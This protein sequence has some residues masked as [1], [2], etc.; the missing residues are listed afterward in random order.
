MTEQAPSKD[1][2][3]ELRSLFDEAG[4]WATR[5]AFGRAHTEELFRIVEA[6]RRERNAS[7]VVAGNALTELHDKCTAH[8]PRLLHG[9][10]RDRAIWICS[11][12]NGWNHVRDKFCTHTH[13]A[14]AEG[15]SPVNML[16]DTS[17]HPPA[18]LRALIGDD[19]Y[20]ATFQSM[21]QY[22]SALLAASS[23]PPVM[24]PI[25]HYGMPAPIHLAGELPPLTDVYVAEELQTRPAQPPVPV[26]VGLP[27]LFREI[28][29]LLGRT[30]EC[31][32]EEEVEFG[33]ISEMLSKLCE[34]PFCP[35][36]GP[37]VMNCEWRCCKCGA[38]MK[39]GLPPAA[40][41]TSTKGEVP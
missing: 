9:I 38:D 37:T 14:N 17:S 22:R 26:P 8:E 15:G 36:C 29:N 20:A 18:D 30:A 28:R 16:V 23:Q 40:Y 4:R 12:C 21:A 19:A 27:S 39:D 11:I 33:D 2:V 5:N 41:S 7:A 24:V 32:D 25:G 34:Q 3:A 13:L 10:P 6:L 35:K 31:F 1:R